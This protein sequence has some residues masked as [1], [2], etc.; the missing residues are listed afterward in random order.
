MIPLP[1]QTLDYREDFDEGLA[2]EVG[3]CQGQIDKNDF[4]SNSVI[5]VRLKK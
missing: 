1:Y 4:K 5:I 2:A 3:M